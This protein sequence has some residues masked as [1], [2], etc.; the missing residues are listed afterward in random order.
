MQRV[1]ALGGHGV[2]TVKGNQPTLQAD[3][4]TFFAAPHASFR[5]G[6][7]LDQ[8]WGRREQ[9]SLRVSTEMHASLQQDWPLGGTSG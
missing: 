2:L 7:T 3:L 5:Q 6:A 4:A 9:R 8:H 1:D